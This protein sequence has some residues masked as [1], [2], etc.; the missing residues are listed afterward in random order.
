MK[1]VNVYLTFNG[2]CRQAFEFY[3]QCFGGELMMMRFADA[4]FDMC[5]DAPEARERIMH[6]S[7]INGSARLMG[8]DTMPNMPVKAG[9]NFSVS[10]ACDNNEQV[11]RYT[12]GVA[13]GGQ[14][15]MEPQETFWAHRFSMCT[16]KFGIK[17]MFIHEKPMQAS[18]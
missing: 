4:P 13:T 7:L 17:W 16:D 3:K 11:D 18:A 2:E 10:I 5:K 9:T 15:F 8:S 1:D 12:K 6:V 14:V